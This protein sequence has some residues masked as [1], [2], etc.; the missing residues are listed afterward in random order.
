MDK[1]GNIKKTKSEDASVSPGV[2]KL[3]FTTSDLDLKKYEPTN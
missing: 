3:F 1:K 2:T